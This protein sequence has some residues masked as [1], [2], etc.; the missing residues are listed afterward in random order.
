MIEVFDIPVGEDFAISIEKLPFSYGW[1]SNT[2]MGFAHWNH[3]IV[4]VRKKNVTPI[5]IPESCASI[6]QAVKAKLPANAYPIRCYANLHTHGVEG[7]PHTDSNRDSE[8]TAVLYCNREWKREWAGETIFFE[9]E[10]ISRA[11]LPR[12]GR[13]VMFT[14]NIVHVARAVSRICPVARITFIIKARHPGEDATMLEDFLVR[15]G[16]DKHKHKEGTL[17]DHL[18]RTYELLRMKKLDREVCL[19]GGLHS[20]Y[21]T[22][23][24]KT[25]TINDRNIIRSVFGNRVESLVYDFS[26]YRPDAPS[27]TSNEFAL[28]RAANL[29]DQGSLKPDS[30]LFQLWNAC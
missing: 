15:V 27:N 16:A 22:E 6:W 21:G 12:L 10:E 14:S 11:V 4:K 19:A 1:R 29:K 8:T 2:A 25:V 17:R 5:Q 23:S 13:L 28:I 18:V 26:R 20:L 30:G 24:Y 7:Y 9:G 3:E